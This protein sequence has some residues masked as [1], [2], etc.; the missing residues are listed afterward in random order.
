M[1]WK[2][3]TSVIG[4]F[5]APLQRK[6]LSAP[7]ATPSRGASAPRLEVAGAERMRVD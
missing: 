6:V 1:S 4:V 5:V 2:A 3:S 7:L